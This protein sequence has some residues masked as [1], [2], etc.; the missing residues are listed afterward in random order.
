MDISKASN[1]ERFI[2]DLLGRDAERVRH[3]FAEVLPA[4]GYFDLSTTEEFAGLRERFGFVS[5]SSTHADRVAQ[6]REVHTRDGVLI[7]PHTADGVKVAREFVRS[8]VPMIVTE[9]ALPVK[10]AETIVEA[11]GEAPPRPAKFA[12]IEDLPRHVIELPNDAEAVK[13]LIAQRVDR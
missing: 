11:I 13:T 3:L 12:G 2:F 9:T 8:G 10:F 7:D 4:Q 6:I 5:S 1:F